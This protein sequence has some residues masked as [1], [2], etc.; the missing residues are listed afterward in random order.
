[1]NGPDLLERKATQFVLWRPRVTDPPPRLVI[2]R[3]QPGNPPALVD[4]RR[5]D[6]Q[7]TRDDLW[8]LATADCG[9]APGVYH[10]GFEVGDTNP[11]PGAA[12][13]RVVCTDPAAWTVDWRLSAERNDAALSVVRWDGQ[14]LSACDPGGEMA[15]WDGDPSSGGLPP[16]NRLVIYE[17]PTGWARSAGGA[18]EVAVGTFRDAMAL[19]DPARGGA[20]FAATAALAPG[21]AHLLELGVT[22]LELLPPADSFFGRGWGYATSNYFAADFDLGFPRAN[23][24]PTPTQDLAALVSLCH[25]QGLRFFLDV[26]MA[27]ARQDAYRNANFADLHVQAN[28]GD[29]EEWLIDAGGGSKRRDGFGGDLWRYNRPMAGYDPVSGETREAL[30]PARQWMKTFAARWIADFRVDGIRVDSVENIGS[31]DFVQEFKDYAR[32]RWHARWAAQGLPAA[33]ADARFLVVGEELAVPLGLVRQNRLDGLWNEEFKRMVRFAVEGRNDPKEPSFEWTVRKL[34]DCR[35]LGFADG[36]QAVNY[37]TSH[38]VGGW[39]NERLYNLLE[40]D[41]IHD[42]EPRI[43]LAFVCLLTAVGIPMILAGEEFADQHD[44]PT[45]DGGKEVD[46]VNFDRL[47]DPWRRRIFE[48]VAR[49]VRLRTSSGA[50]A[51]NDTAFLHVDF[52]DGKRVLVWQRG[53]PESGELVVVVTN[54]SDWGTPNPRDPHAEYVVP[55]WPATPSGRRWREVTQGR[56]VPAAWVGREPLYPWEAK[57]YVL[58]GD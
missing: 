4:E 35:N 42:T 15:E 41:G 36:A 55:N 9:L 8:A 37:V 7:R 22:A 47:A 49:L 26:V 16:N 30:F 14:R 51:V 20:N 33:D 38:D 50:L 34:I 18:V 40:N 11:Y 17:L 28:A 2:G 19:L 25:Q 31:W 24:S 6:L 57:V 52:E 3:L 12:G 1:M 45:G 39:R 54:F 43:K 21:R 56:D 46:P 13:G 10:Y 27:F 5:F 58:V 29:P 23:L 48:Y 44:L 32:E 53:R